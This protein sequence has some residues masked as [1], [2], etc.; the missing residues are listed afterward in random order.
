MRTI[1]DLWLKIDNVLSAHQKLILFIILFAIFFAG[2][3]P[4][5]FFLSNDVS[6][7]DGGN[8]IH[9]QEH[10]LAYYEFPLH[11]GGQRPSAIDEFSIEIVIRSLPQQT[12]RFSFI[13]LFLSG[14]HEE[15]F[16]IGQWRS[17]L[18]L[19]NGDDYAY[20]RKLKRISLD[21]K[22]LPGREHYITVTSGDG[23]TKLY[24]DGQ[25]IIERKDI[26]FTIPEGPAN[27]KVILGNS[28]YGKHSWEGDILGFAFFK[29]LLASTDIQRNY[30]NWVND[31]DFLFQKRNDPYLLYSFDGT[32]NSV[33]HDQSGGERHLI[34]PSFI[35]VIHKEVLALP[36]R[37]SLFHYNFIWL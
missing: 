4:R 14:K 28:P 24:S 9:F 33:V 12:P 26:V 7:I 3:K 5:E 35:E 17:W 25:Q 36:T 19:M 21:L 15:Q 18:I 27:T 1:K 29:S 13:V 30:Q 34:I 31:H 23:G 32:I 6:F 22:T 2:F 11:D 37:N 20:K 16:L 8:G 10:S